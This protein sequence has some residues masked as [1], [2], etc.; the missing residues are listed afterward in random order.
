MKEL[1][2]LSLEELIDRVTEER[3]I[4]DCIRGDD[5]VIIVQ[6]STR[7]V[8]D[9]GRAHT[10]LRGVIKGM[11]AE[12]RRRVAGRDQTCDEA[13]HRVRAGE[14]AGPFDTFRRHL[15]KKWWGRYEAAGKPCGRSIRGLMVW[16]RYNTATTA[17]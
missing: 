7:F 13:D 1:E 9:P 8:L 2:A 5:H 15:V 14:K 11:S 4:D 17:N 6:G 3:L 16:I 12:Y 10:F